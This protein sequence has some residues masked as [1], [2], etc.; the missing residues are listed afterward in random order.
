MEAGVV[1]ALPFLSRK[2]LMLHSLFLFWQTL[3]DVANRSWATLR[4]REPNKGKNVFGT[5]YKS[6]LYFV[7]VYQ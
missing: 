2:R 4:T 1:K 7:F 3:R 6:Y 5:H